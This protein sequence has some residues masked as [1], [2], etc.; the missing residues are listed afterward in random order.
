MC[1]G[2]AVFF[3]VKKVVIGENKNMSGREE[4]L[5]QH[6]I[7]VVILN[8]QACDELMTDFITNKPHLW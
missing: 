2:A 6:G 3:K 4:F 5:R 8:N 1:A 7:E